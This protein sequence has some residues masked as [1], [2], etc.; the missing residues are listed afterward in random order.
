MGVCEKGFCG[1]GLVSA[2]MGVLAVHVHDPFLV[3]CISDQS[4]EYLEQRWI[5][6]PYLPSS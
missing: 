2:V 6:S 4:Y 3:Y 5:R 1:S